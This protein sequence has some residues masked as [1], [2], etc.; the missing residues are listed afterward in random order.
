MLRTVTEAGKIKSKEHLIL[1][2]AVFHKQVFAHLLSV[3]PYLHEF[4]HEHSWFSWY[5]QATSWRR[6]ESWGQRCL[7]DIPGRGVWL[8]HCGC[9]QITDP[10][11]SR[12]ASRNT[13][14]E[15]SWVSWLKGLV[16]PAVGFR[17][18]PRVL[19]DCRN[20]LSQV[21][22]VVFVL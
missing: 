19:E 4:F 6:R 22:I 15:V 2:L 11:V 1:H 10:C 9:F 13:A 20:I 16:Q 8:L 12:K 18:C 14:V 3:E 17:L 7:W 21:D 5:P